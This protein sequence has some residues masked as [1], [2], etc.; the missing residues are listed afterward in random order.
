MF[1]EQTFGSGFRKKEIVITTTEQYPQDLLIEFTQDKIGLLNAYAVGDEVK[2]SINLKGREWTSPDGVVKYFTSINGWR[3]EK[4]GGQAPPEAPGFEEIP[5][6][7]PGD[8]REEQ[9]SS[10]ESDDLPF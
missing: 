3:I 2:I 6:G 1:D 8:Y 5:T 10:S 7:T 9:G 4:M